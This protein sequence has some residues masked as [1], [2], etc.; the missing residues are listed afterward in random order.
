[1]IRIFLKCKYKIF[2]AKCNNIK[3]AALKLKVV[4]LQ[5]TNTFNLNVEQISSAFL[6]YFC[7]EISAPT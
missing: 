5:C 6:Q 7:P 1:M 3:I 4:F 2:I